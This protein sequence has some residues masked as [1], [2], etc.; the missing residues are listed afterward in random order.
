MTSNPQR[1]RL[2]NILLLLAST[3]LTLVALEGGVRLF[4]L[5]PRPL[6]ALPVKHYRLAEEPVLRYEY[7]PYPGV[8]RRIHAGLVTNS[9]GFRDY[10]YSVQKP[11]GVRRLVVLGDSTTVG[12]RL[13]NIADTY[14][15]RIEQ[16]LNGTTTDP[17][18]YDYEV[19]SLAVGGYQTL[20]EVETLRLKGLRYEPDAVLLTFC[21][22]DYDLSSDGGVFDKLWSYRHLTQ[23]SV[24][25]TPW[26][27]RW[28]RRSRLAFMVGHRL[29]APLSEQDRI[30]AERFL[31]RRSTVRAGFELLSELQQE[32]GFPVLVVILPAL[33]RP[34]H[35]YRSLDIHQRVLED[36][37]GLPGLNVVDLLPYF[38]ATGLE[39][40]ELARDPVHPNAE[41]HKLLADILL[42]FLYLGP[43]GE[44][45]WQVEGP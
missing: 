1:R 44:L 4:D 17:Q 42:R 31:G 43:D 28:L 15:K 13:K 27:R 19:L 32:H 3:L 23:G 33:D 24:P 39:A 20:Q 11:D 5:P 37:A 21:I 30:Y 26:W 2:G 45:G 38:A 22:N 6:E 34:F 40:S 29:R 8:I 16:A 35:N 9:H 12:A 10:E 36:A 25:E 41:G 14:P 7:R 18:D